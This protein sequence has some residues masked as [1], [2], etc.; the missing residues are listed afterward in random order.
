[1]CRKVLRQQRVLQGDAFLLVKAQSEL[2]GS[3]G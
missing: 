3:Q 2:G 1:M